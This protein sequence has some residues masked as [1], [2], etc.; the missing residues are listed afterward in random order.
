MLVKHHLLGQIAG[1]GEGEDVREGSQ[2]KRL[3]VALV[4]EVVE[5]A[6]TD[7]HVLA[8]AKPSILSIVD[9]TVPEFI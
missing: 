9:L 7:A 4:G 5:S 6:A 2:A 1:V 8:L 3:L